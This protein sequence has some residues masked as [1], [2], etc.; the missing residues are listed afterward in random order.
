MHLIY[1]IQNICKNVQLKICRN[2]YKADTCTICKHKI[3]M[4]KYALPILLMSVSH[5]PECR[6]F[7]E[8][9]MF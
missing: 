3:Y 8:V 5:H 1:A 6:N 7:A 9:K 4:Q 2:I